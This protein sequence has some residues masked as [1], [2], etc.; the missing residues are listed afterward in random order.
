MDATKYKNNLHRY[1]YSFTKHTS[2]CITD[3]VLPTHKI[4]MDYITEGVLTSHQRLYE[5]WSYANGTLTSIFRD[6]VIL[7]AVFQYSVADI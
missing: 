3:K 6:I 5:Q 1:V 2:V 4:Q 7:C